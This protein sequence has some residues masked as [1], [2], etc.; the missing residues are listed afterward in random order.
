MREIADGV[1]QL[2]GWPPNNVNVYVVGD[3]LIDAGLLIHRGRI[4]SQLG[5]RHITA[6]ALTHAHFDHYGSSHAVCEKLRIPLWCGAQDAPAVEAGKMVIRGGRLVPAAKAHPVSRSLK[7]GDEVAGFR[8]LDTPGH[9]PGHVSYWREPDRV[10]LCGDVMWGYDP[11]LFS[12]GI[13]EPYPVA[14]PDPQRNR[15]S[16]RRLAALEPQLVCF[17]HGPPT[18][19]TDRFVRAVERLAS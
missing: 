15:D 13:R 3:V 5:D 4:L 17:G 11:F 1:W 18:R 10:R 14:S 9:S 6:N 2:S 19:D 12:G 16:A 7:E 8:V